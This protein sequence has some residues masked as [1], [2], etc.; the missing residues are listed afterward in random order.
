MPS[1]HATTARTQRASARRRPEG[2]SGIVRHARL[3]NEQI[4][5]HS[6]TARGAVS[7][8]FRRVLLW[9]ESSGAPMKTRSALFLFAAAILAGVACGR[10]TLELPP[11]T[12]GGSMVT[13]STGTPCNG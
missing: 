2:I 12:D 6:E 11:G 3:A 10:T 8:T 13:C 7:S 1:R 5:Q 4:H 9:T